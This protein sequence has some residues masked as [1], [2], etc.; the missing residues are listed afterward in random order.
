[1]CYYYNANTKIQSNSNYALLLTGDAEL[2]RNFG[3]RSK[4]VDW[5]SFLK[6]NHLSHNIQIVNLPHHGASANTNAQT[7]E[8]LN[9][10][11]IFLTFS[12]L[13]NS[14]E[15]PRKEAINHAIQAQ[16]NANII[17]VNQYQGLEEEII[18]GLNRH[19]YF[20]RTDTD[21]PCA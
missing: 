20:N 6:P 11:Q 1:M 15:H 3:P 21:K 7:F 8:N 12:G 10:V 13:F 18:I 19:Y 17:H 5:Q 4:K 9:N 14:H 16:Q 2:Y